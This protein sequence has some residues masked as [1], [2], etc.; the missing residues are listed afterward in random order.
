MQESRKLKSAIL[1]VRKLT[2]KYASI[3]NDAKMVLTKSLFF[4]WYFKPISGLLVWCQF[5][6]SIKYFMEVDQEAGKIFLILLYWQ[7]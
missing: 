2:F 7:Y 6:I 4:F 1:K 5:W 3:K